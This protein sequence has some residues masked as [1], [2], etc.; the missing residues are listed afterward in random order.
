VIIH[1]SRCPHAVK[2]VSA[3]ADLLIQAKWT[4]YKILSFLARISIQGIDKFG[5]YNQITTVISKE[6]NVNMRAIILPVMMVFLRDNGFIC[7]QC[8]GFKQSCIKPFEH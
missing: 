8:K 2:L 1:K 6:L 4:T 5:I 3:H 7:A